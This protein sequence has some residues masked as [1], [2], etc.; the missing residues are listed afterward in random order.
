MIHLL[1]VNVLVALLW[2]AHVSH[3]KAQHWFGQN[4]KKGWA[5]CPLTQAAAVR[6]LSNPSFSPDALTVQEAIVIMSAGLQHPNHQFWA[7]D[8]G[9][10]QAVKP[11]QKLLLGHQQVT[12]AYLL[13]L[14]V[15]HKGKFVTMDR[16]VPTML[17]QTNG[18]G[19]VVEVI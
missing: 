15:H 6:I 9:I 16:A 11:F 13:G 10:I 18:T 3:A 7:D 4:A 17:P 14:T 8:M 1:D 2:P 19:S 5:T 12:D